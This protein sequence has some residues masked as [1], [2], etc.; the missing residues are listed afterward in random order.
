MQCFT[1]R[2][3]TSAIIG[4]LAMAAIL[5]GCQKA[6]PAAIAPPS[7]R[8]E[9][10]AWAS[11]AGEYLEA[12]F[13]AHPSFAAQQGRHEY[14]GLLPDWS[15]TGI[16]AETARLK[17]F[18]ER[19]SGFPDAGL[20]DAERVERD[21]LLTRIDRDIF[22]SDIAEAPFRNP[23]FYIGMDDGGDTLDPSVYVL[24][25]YGTPEVRLKA[26]IR[27]ARSVAQAVPDIRK[28]LRTPM[29]ATYIKLGASN[30]DGL[31]SF[32][33][34]DVPRVFAGVGDAA[35]QA[36]LAAAIEPA[37]AALEGLARW[38]QSGASH[39]TGP[40]PLG[41][42]RF[43]Q[44]LRMTESVEIPLADLEAAGRAD[45]DRNTAAL[46][47]ACRQFAPGASLKRCV[48][49]EEDHKPE[50]GAVAG[51]RA[52]LAGLRQF[53]IDKDIV[54]I[55]GT[56]Q[57][58]VEEAPPFNR[59]N[60]AYIDIPG[61]YDKGLPSV[62]YIAPPDPAW[63]RAEQLAYV[64]GE[65]EL[66]FTSVH[67]VWPGHFLQFLWAKR[68]PSKLASVFGSYAFIEGWAHYGEELMWE[69]GLGGNPEIHVGQ[70]SNALLR[71]VRFLSSIGLHT[72]GMTVAESERLFREVAFQNAGEARQQAARGTYDPG[73]LNYTLGKLM[74]RKLRH[75]YC[76]NRGGEAAWK[77]YH[78]VL[79]SYGAL[80]VPLLRRIML[81][82]DR[83]A[84]LP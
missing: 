82:G 23:E 53:I 79:L 55:P 59:Q 15:A 60:F 65:S 22:W 31:A 10:L 46:T 19:V 24:R 17:A 13:K 14:D 8:T 28:N 68:A 5:C 25:P 18:R 54:T 69:K 27:Y 70:L 30:F 52:Q 2:L 47:Q 74:I 32:Y 39:A 16:R 49:R 73:Y 84:L 71:N 63:P 80:P 42:V 3:R 66:L 81:P 44:M 45:L 61:P 29:P 64:P 51:A 7:G 26:F 21:Y 35:L 34:Q 78:D 83:G 77:S 72:K 43:A 20:T 36:E 50:G 6:A 40:D 75:D 48:E 9:A 1:A 38:L 58:S 57:V 67:E 37:A 76:A 62:Y 33:R 56:E 41:A 11:L 12:Y 4:I